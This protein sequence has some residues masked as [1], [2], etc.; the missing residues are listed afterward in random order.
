[1]EGQENRYMTIGKKQISIIFIIV[2]HIVG[3]IG[4]LTPFLHDLFISLVPFHL[5]LMA[6]ILIINQKEFSGNFWIGAIV[7]TLAGFLVE[8][9][10]VKT[11]LVF[12]EYN[13]GKTLG[14]KLAD[15]PLMIGVNWFIIV[16]SLGSYLK[17]KFKHQQTIKS[18]V[19]AFFL[20]LLDY[21]IE[22][23]A[24][25]QDYWSWAGN[26]IP[27]QNFIGWYIV[28][29]LMFRFYF[30]LDFRKSNAVGLTLFITQFLFFVIL[31]IAMP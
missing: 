15:I 14:L 19:G 3:L 5:L 13:Y 25:Q 29:F 10:G 23:V 30:A 7:I 1:M 22:P 12:G 16:F 18:L 8:L 21:F 24:I 26:V 17:R 6:G 4:F 27:L 28:S 2:F 9:I 20:V 11:G 31:N